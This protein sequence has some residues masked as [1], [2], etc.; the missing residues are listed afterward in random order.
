MP[1]FSFFERLVEPTAVSPETP[2]PPGL[3]AFYWH[4][5]RQIRGL[6]GALFVTGSLV[7]VLDLLIPIFIGR[8]VNLVS[9]Y[10]PA[11]VLREHWREL[12]AMATVQLGVRPVILFLQNLITN[13]AI[14]PG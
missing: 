8:V 11:E 14:A 13:Q 4:F 9:T 10:S 7:A 2:P 5:A 1:V 6:I 12:L 3:V